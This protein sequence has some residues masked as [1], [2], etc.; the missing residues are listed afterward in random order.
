MSD[1]VST[2]RMHQALDG[3]LSS[4]ELQEIEDHALSC[5]VCRTEHAR[6]SEVVSALRALPR[7]GTAPAKAAR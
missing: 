5:A 2:E 4:A 6:L 7:S 1:H 3:E